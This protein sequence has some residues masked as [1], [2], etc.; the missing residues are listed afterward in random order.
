M[1]INIDDLQK[2][3][4]LLL[5]KTKDSQGNN[6][7]IDVDYYWDIDAANLYN[8]YEAPKD[9]GLG[10]LSF[11]I[12]QINKISASGTVVPYD[13]KRAGGILAAL[14]NSLLHFE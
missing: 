1:N 4:L 8:P 9:I 3:I 2:S 14:G 6:V 11:D 13:L 7:V 10:Q 12:E 5:R